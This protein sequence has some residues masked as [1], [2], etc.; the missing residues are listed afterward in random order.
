MTPGDQPRPSSMTVPYVGMA[1]FE[2]AA[3]PSRR[4]CADQAALHAVNSL[5]TPF[6]VLPR[7]TLSMV[8]LCTP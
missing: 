1:R 5:Y 3:P 7:T 4:E 6:Q 2:L 8:L